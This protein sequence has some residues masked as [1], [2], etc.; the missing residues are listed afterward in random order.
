MKKILPILAVSALLCS[1]E[2]E[3]KDIYSRQIQI[4]SN[5][6]GTTIVIDGLRLGKTPMSVGVE[7]NDSG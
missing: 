3:D 4:D 6:T 1:C 5:P 7:T 2:T